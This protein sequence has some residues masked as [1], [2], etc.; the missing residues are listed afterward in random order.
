MV[1]VATIGSLEPVHPAP[2]HPFSRLS[3]ADVPRLDAHRSASALTVARGPPQVGPDLPV[4]GQ[5]RPGPVG[6]LVE[7]ECFHD[8]GNGPAD[9]P[10]VDPLGPGE[11]DRL[12]RLGDHTKPPTERGEVG[13]HS[14]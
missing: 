5:P 7:H 2:C 10:E 8:V 1:M 12:H 11:P 4:V 3:S 6:L 13:Q 9:Q 14:V